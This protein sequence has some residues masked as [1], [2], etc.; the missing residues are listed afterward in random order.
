MSARTP[1]SLTDIVPHAIGA[2]S[3]GGAI[4][5]PYW[6]PLFQSGS[7]WPVALLPYVG[8]VLVLV[9]IVYWLVRLWRLVR[10]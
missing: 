8:I 3:A 4:S 10:P 2:V 7:A 6:L 1:M 5:A 9:Q